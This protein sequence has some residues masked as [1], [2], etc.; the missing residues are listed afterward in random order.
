MLFLVVFNIFGAIGKGLAYQ[1]RSRFEHKFRQEK[2]YKHKLISPVAL[3]GRPHCL[4]RLSY[5]CLQLQQQLWVIR[6]HPMSGISHLSHASGIQK[7]T[8]AFA[9]ERIDSK[10]MEEIALN[11]WTFGQPCLEDVDGLTCI[12]QKCT[13]ASHNTD[14]GQSEDDRIMVSMYFLPCPCYLSVP[15]QLVWQGGSSSMPTF[16][17]IASSYIPTFLHKQT[18]FRRED[19][20][21]GILYRKEKYPCPT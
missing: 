11:T 18:K 7:D 10:D 4:C 3:G 13:I 2:P 8:P 17:E 12:N 5:K 20:K 21:Q 19:Q 6:L 15:V 1:G 9:L 14:L 16:P